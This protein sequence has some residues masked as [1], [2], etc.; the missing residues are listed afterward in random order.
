VISKVE[1]IGALPDEAVA[2][3]AEGRQRQLK[4]ANPARDPITYKNI[5]AMQKNVSAEGQRKAR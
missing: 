4:A 1:L 5:A 2:Y 3:G